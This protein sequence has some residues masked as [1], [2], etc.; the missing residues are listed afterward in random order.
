MIDAR[1]IHIDRNSRVRLS[2]TGQLNPLCAG[3]A[4]LVQNVVLSLLTT[5]GSSAMSPR[6]GAGLGEFCR[7][8]RMENDTLT[9]AVAE[10]IKELEFLILEEQKS[11][12]LSDD[13]RLVSLDV[14]SVERSMTDRTEVLIEVGLR[15]AAGASV[16]VA[17]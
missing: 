9:E 10:R 2:I 13:E 16:S 3:L 5:P 4:G 11:L 15:N 14:I 8:S 7:R 1:I 12:T 6:R 17:I